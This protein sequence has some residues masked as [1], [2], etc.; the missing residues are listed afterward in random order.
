MTDINRGPLAVQKLDGKITQI[1][2]FLWGKS[3]WFDAAAIVVAKWTPLVML[4]VY[5]VATMHFPLTNHW[6][7]NRTV[8]A[9]FGITSAVL[10]RFINEPLGRMMNRPRPFELERFTPLTSHEAGKSFPSNHA[11][12]AFAL[13]VS[14]HSVPTYSTILYTLAVLLCVTRVYTG[15]HHLTDVLAGILHGTIAAQVVALIGHSLLSPTVFH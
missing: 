9:F 12:G 2:R 1:C 15:V 5:I 10:I 3:L 11:T 8:S 14:F 4:G 13:A 7:N 6:V